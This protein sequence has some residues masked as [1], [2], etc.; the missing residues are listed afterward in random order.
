MRLVP[1]V[2]LPVFVLLAAPL[3]AQSQSFGIGGRMAM[4]RA[5]VD[6]DTDSQRFTGLHIRAGLSPRTAFELSLDRRTETNDDETLRVRELPLQ[7]SLLLFL[8]RTTF[9]PYVLGGGGWYSTRVETLEDDETIASES[10]R[11]FGW[12]AGFGAEIKLGRHA[13]IHADYRYTRL[14]FGDDDETDGEEESG[15]S[16][17]VP[18]YRG[19]M[20]T[21]GLTFYF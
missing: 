10:T 4:V 19:S 21:A 8:T 9:A 15:F 6:A 18:S 20:W 13:G 7:A 3:P 16:R 1:T 14:N 17:F 2:V 12:H 11:P 5:D